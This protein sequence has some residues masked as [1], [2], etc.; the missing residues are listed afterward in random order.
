MS[1]TNANSGEGNG[2]AKLEGKPANVVQRMKEKDLI[3]CDDLIMTTTDQLKVEGDTSTSNTNES[4][5][6]H[7]TSS[8][9]K[10]G[11]WVAQGKNE[12]TLDPNLDPNGI[13][14]VV[15]PSKQPENKSSP[16]NVMTR[17]MSVL[18]Y[19]ASD[20]GGRPRV[21][22][23]QNLYDL[24]MEPPREH[25]IPIQITTRRS[26]GKHEIMS[27]NTFEVAEAARNRT[28][29][30]LQRSSSAHVLDSKETQ[31]E[32]DSGKS[33]QDGT[34]LQGTDGAGRPSKLGYY[35]R[36]KT[37]PGRPKS[38]LSSD[39]KA[40]GRQRAADLDRAM[41]HDNENDALKKSLPDPNNDSRHRKYKKKDEKPSSNFSFDNFNASI[42]KLPP[43]RVHTAAV[44]NSVETSLDFGGYQPPLT[45]AAPSTNAEVAS[46]KALAAEGEN[47]NVVPT[48]ERIQRH[49]KAISNDRNRSHSGQ[50]RSQGMAKLSFDFH[51]KYS[52]LQE[53]NEE[54]S[55]WER[56]MAR[57]R[58]SQNDDGKTLV[59]TWDQEGSSTLRGGNQDFEA[60]FES[61]DQSDRSTASDF[62]SLDSGDDHSHKYY[63]SESGSGRSSADEG[64]QE[65]E[66]EAQPYDFASADDTTSASSPSDQKV[67][68]AHGRT[69]EVETDSYRRPPHGNG[70]RLI[71]RKQ[72]RKRKQQQQKRNEEFTDMSNN[73]IDII[74]EQDLHME[75]D[76]NEMDD[77]T[78]DQFLGKGDSS[79]GDEDFSENVHG[80]YAP[81]GPLNQHGTKQCNL[82]STL[83]SE[84]LSLFA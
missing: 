74:E 8:S 48:K 42:G 47:R 17:S 45:A 2:G 83:G 1:N 82:N 4:N 66:I 53:A 50:R 18:E 30:T 62:S 26:D 43:R 46:R 79:N 64:S 52:G 67:G 51:T 22:Q 71:S 23:M 34:S 36:P 13:S 27:T 61:E 3:Y 73:I 11:S 10:V 69:S 25:P 16:K 57:M 41:A 35:K 7:D 55:K 78:E 28:M 60:V 80:H 44:D 38:A 6:E 76:I 21:V 59:T 81:V 39:R 12:T 84:F 20:D 19:V 70:R 77:Y 63:T 58:A 54:L 5:V 14:E 24:T 65:V 40:T 68:W 72:F 56:E 33:E 49:G 75:K 37:P 9:G 31:S 32:V 29:T 15:S